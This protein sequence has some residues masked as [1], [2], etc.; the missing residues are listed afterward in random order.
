LTSRDAIS[1]PVSDSAT[2]RVSERAAS[3]SATA[4]SMFSSSTPKTMS[5]MPWAMAKRT[6]ASSW[7]S[8]AP[9]SGR[10]RARAVMRTLMPSMP[11]AKK[12]K[13]TS[14]EP[15]S[16]ATRSASASARPDSL[17]PQVRST[18]LAMTPSSPASAMRARRSGRMPRS[19][20]SIIS[21]GTPGTAYTTLLPT[22]QT[23]P[24][25]VPAWRMSVAPRGTSAWRSLFAVMGRPRS[26]KNAAMSASTDASRSRG[27]PITSAIASRVM[28]S[29]V[30]PSPPQVITPSLRANAV[31]SASTMR[32][33][34]SPTAWWKCDATPLAARCSPNQAELV[35]AIC[36]SSSSVPTAT[37]SILT[38][39]DLTAPPPRGARGDHA[40][41]P[42][43]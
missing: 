41:P 11:E 20:M 29:C 39:S 28:S 30:G 2:A 27:T 19:N 1:P 21:Q 12:A 31:R 34:L 24:G 10:V 26:S 14:P 32:S 8:R 16:A 5:P 23:R 3:R 42:P 22:G 40:A 36:P 6:S 33:W 38:G 15:S 9:T 25:A 18:R 37:I 7:S 43:R 35:S 4:T 17:A 13:V